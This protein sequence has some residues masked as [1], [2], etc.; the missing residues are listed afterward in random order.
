MTDAKPLSVAIEDDP[1]S[2]EE[3]AR[4]C[5]RQAFLF[6]LHLTRQREEAADVAQDAML[7][8][9]AALDRFD[10]GRP[11]RPWLFRI[12]RNLI[13][14][15]ARRMRVRRTVSLEGAQG[16]LVVDPVAPDLNPESAAERLQLQRLVWRCVDG[17]TPEHRE[18]LVLRDYHGLTYDEIAEVLEI[19][20]GTVMSRLHRAR[21][22]I[23]VEVHRR[24]EGPGPG[25]E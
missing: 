4:D 17:L 11:V 8:F 2:R 9:F 13:R 16:D 1:S 12:V 5:H 22:R 18:V 25:G 21:R 20:R 10:A 14:D 3:L 23:H 7:R 24:L 6:A 19:P 15:R